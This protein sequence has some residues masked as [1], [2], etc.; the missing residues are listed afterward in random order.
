MTW[1]VINSE[2]VVVNVVIWNG[3]DNLFDGFT[4]V[5]LEENEPCSPGWTYDPNSTPRFVEPITPDPVP[6]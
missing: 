6:E 2:N 4:T 5:Q 1:A 3:G